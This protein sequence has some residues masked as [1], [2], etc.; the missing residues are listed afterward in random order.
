MVNACAPACTAMRP[1][2]ADIGASSGVPLASV[3]VSKPMPMIFLSSSLCGQFGRGGQVQIAEYHL[4]CVEQGDFCGLRLFYF[5]DELRFVH[6]CRVVHDLCAGGAVGVVWKAD[7]RSGA[8][9][10]ANLVSCSQQRGDA[11]RGEGD[12]IL[13]ILDFLGNA[14]QH[15]G[16]LAVRVW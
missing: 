7:A 13:V 10:H 6:G 3:T 5:N 14:D 9:L 2:T 11:V 15:G 1:A 12:A 16:V 8:G 4:P